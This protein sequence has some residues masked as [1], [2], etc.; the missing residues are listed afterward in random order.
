MKFG[1]VRATLAKVAA[2]AKVF[3][4][5]PEV[6][7]GPSH[8]ARARTPKTPK[9]GKVQ[10]ELQ[11]MQRTQLMRRL[12]PA[13]MFPY[14]VPGPKTDNIFIGHY[15]GSDDE[16]EQEPNTTTAESQPRPQPTS[17]LQN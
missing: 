17:D 5:N 4:P 14:H 7:N 3:L 15:V 10:V 9:N 2:D 12:H 8:R 1:T 6:K 11:N 13:M 16:E